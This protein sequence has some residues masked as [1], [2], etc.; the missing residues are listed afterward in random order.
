MTISIDLLTHVLSQ[1]DTSVLCDDERDRASRFHNSS[2]QRRYIAGRTWLRRT[3]GAR[4]DRPP[5][6]L[7]F[8]YGRYG[9]PRVDHADGVHFNL[10]HSGDIAVL[11]IGGQ[12]PVGVDVERARKDVYDRRAAA[13][14]FHESELQAIDDSE[15]PDRR[16][17]DIWTRKEAMVKVHGVGLQRSLASFSVLESPQRDGVT[18]SAVDVGMDSVACAV[19][20]E[21]SQPFNVVMCT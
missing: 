21:T 6:E 9:K 16:F 10:A 18:V 12:A 14:V 7:R 13:L 15:D 8:S 2:D 1:D 5:E 17:V 4:I 19:A 3:L 11:A 20:T